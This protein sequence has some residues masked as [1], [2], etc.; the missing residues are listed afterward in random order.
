MIALYPENKSYERKTLVEIAETAGKSPA[1]CYVDMVC[2]ST[3]PLAI[4]FDYIQNNVNEIMSKADIITASDGLTVPGKFVK[5]YPACYGTFPRRYREC[6]I[7][8]K[9]MSVA[10]AIRTMTS[11]PAE[12]FNMKERGKIAKNYYADIA[13]INLNTFRSSATY[14]NPSQ[15]SEGVMHLF[16]NGVQSIENGE[17]THTRGGRGLIMV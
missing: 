12:K 4:F 16:V 1:D 11:L 9:E 10:A 8:R 2:E 14:M 6:V 13:V 15:Y 5:L 17:P 3:A 7:N